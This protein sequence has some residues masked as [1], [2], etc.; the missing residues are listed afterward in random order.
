VC[1][2]CLRERQHA[3]EQG[4]AVRCDQAGLAGRGPVGSRFGAQVRGASPAS[5]G[6]VVLGVATSEE[7]APTTQVAVGSVQ[8]SDRR[9]AAGGSGR[10]AQAA[11]HRRLDR[12]LDQTGG[13]DRGDPQRPQGDAQRRQRSV[14]YTERRCSLGEVTAQSPDQPCSVSPARVCPCFACPRQGTN[15]K[16]TGATSSFATRTRH[17]WDVLSSHNPLDPSNPLAGSGR[18]II[19]WS[20]TLFARESAGQRPDCASHAFG[21]STFVP[22][23]NVHSGPASG[24]YTSAV[25]P[26][27]YRRAGT[28]EDCPWR[29]SRAR[30]VSSSTRSALIL[31]AAHAPADADMPTWAARSVTFPAAQTPGTLV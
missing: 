6:G 20:P 10:A 31:I 4:R 14:R 18:L 15:Q 3:P 28:F 12:A 23:M 5:A 22:R 17:Q 8:A 1:T 9:D 24:R 7:E 19:E 25:R 11:S 2:A 30:R 29:P 21:C 16:G 27:D 26:I 13:D